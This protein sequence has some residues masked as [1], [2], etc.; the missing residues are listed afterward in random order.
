MMTAPV[1]R[2][3]LLIG[4]GHSHALLIRQWAMNPL[5]GVRLTLVSDGVL[6]P[7]SGMLP[8]L[9]AGHYT[10]DEVHIDLFRL[11]MLAGV[12]FINTRMTAIDVDAKRVELVDRP[13]LCFDVLSLDTGSTP[14]LSV[15][16][17]SEYSTPVKPVHAFHARWQIIRQRIEASASDK[18]WEVGVVGSGAGGFE[19]AMA[20]R[21]ALPAARAQ[22]HWFL[23]GDKPLSGRADKVR[24]RALDEALQAG[25]VVHQDFDVERVLPGP[26]LQARDDRRQPLDELL[27]C[28]GAVGPDWVVG[29]GLATDQRGFV[30]TDAY[31]RS[32]SHP[33]VF[34]TGD[35]GTQ[36]DTPS[37]KAGVYAVRQA[38]I[39]YENLRRSLL[40]QPLR[41]YRPQHDFLSL[42]AL[43]PKRAI[44]SRG[45]F[46]SVG[47]WVWR[48]KDRIDRRFMDR[49]HDV[50]PMGNRPLGAVVHKA[51]LDESFSDAGP[52]C[53][54]CGA[55]V[56]AKVLNASLANIT[57]NADTPGIH[58]GLDH[59]G[60]A[61]AFDAGDQWV[62][63]SVD[64][65]SALVDDPWLFT[66]IAV[67]HALADVL[68][69]GA[70]PHS[71]QLMLT[72]P[73]AAQS[74]HQR[75]LDLIMGGASSALAEEG[76][77]LV[78][79][80]TSEGA[81][82]QVGLVVNGLIAPHG[83]P[84]VTTC[85]PGD[86]LLLTRGIGSG[87]LFAA[88]MRGRAAGVT[89]A[90]ALRTMS[91]SQRAVADVLFDHQP[92]AVTDVTGF[93]LA[94]HLQQLL[95]GSQCRARIDV[96]CIPMLDGAWEHARHG[97]TSSLYASNADVLQAVDLSVRPDNL[98]T[99]RHLV[100]D[101]Q[102]A[103][104]F[105]AVLPGDRADDALEVIREHAREAAIVGSLCAQ[106]ELAVHVFEE[107]TTV[108][109]SEK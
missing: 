47:R 48:W 15:P 22:V 53:N 56:A 101:P 77:A 104:G 108:N 34:A 68:S 11:C 96:S 87:V 10:A 29:A 102:T 51:L 24:Q 6:T 17:A 52:R 81:E 1:M 20:M 23:R 26:C 55:K 83:L 76:L 97:I 9:V 8:G 31:L 105:L 103:G 86:R 62:V 28:T 100:C 19:I 14:D 16:G 88:A 70:R 95:E 39:L 106:A 7:Y 66:R 49:I 2:D 82:L 33:E 59:R 18:R 99:W 27:W 91:A 5:P 43:G 75:E 60:D 41:V 40:S 30:L 72:L 61:A 35:I 63:Q 85:V 98:A 69:Q 107:A 65:L 64:Q 67:R 80:H 109:R 78:G 37:P 46:M 42:M 38:P 3:V 79:G 13:S 90:A 94:G 71:A 89:L 21:H 93:G 12:R 36:R 73:R 44:A 50:P 45:P 84:D 54:G 32:V 57:A 74:I 58:L 92:R 25:I 4:G